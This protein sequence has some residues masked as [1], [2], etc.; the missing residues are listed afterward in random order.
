M[1]LKCAVE[2]GIADIIH[3]HG[4]AI[5]LSDLVSELNTQPT[6]TTGLFRLMHFLVH[7]GCFNKIKVNGQ[8]EEEEAYGLTPFST[9]LIKENSYCLSTS[10]FSI[11]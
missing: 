7:L 6:K 11:C 4:R 2:L 3:G 5:T 8:E 10:C 9:L 1:L